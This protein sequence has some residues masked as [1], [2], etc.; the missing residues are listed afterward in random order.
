MTGIT[1]A[2]LIELTSADHVPALHGQVSEESR[3]SAF[4][5]LRT[6]LRTSL[7]CH[8]RQDTE[9]LQSAPKQPVLRGFYGK[10]E[11]LEM[12][13]QDEKNKPS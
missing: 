11:L 9:R 1:G 12:L 8:L 10:K 4:E 5:D 3:V 2:K 13:T 7:W 6:G